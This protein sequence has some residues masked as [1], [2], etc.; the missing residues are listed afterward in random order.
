MN[1]GLSFEDARFQSLLS[2]IRSN[3]AR[4][5]ILEMEG[6]PDGD[7]PPEGEPSEPSPET[8]DLYDH[9]VTSL[10]ESK[11]KKG[12]LH[13][14]LSD[15]FGSNEPDEKPSL[16]Q[17][18]IGH[19]SDKDRPK[20][21]MFHHVGSHAG[22]GAAGG[23]ALGTTTGALIGGAAGSLLGLPGAI[24]G[25]KAG[26]VL[27][28]LGGA[29][30]G[31]IGGIF[32]AHGAAEKERKRRKEAEKEAASGYGKSFTA[33]AGGA[34]LTGAAIAGLG[35]LA[36]KAHDTYRQ[37]QHRRAVLA[38]TVPALQAP[39]PGYGHY[40]SPHPQMAYDQSAMMHP[41]PIHGGHNNRYRGLLPEHTHARSA[42]VD[43][44]VDEIRQRRS[45]TNEERRPDSGL[46]GAGAQALR[47]R[48]RMD[49]FKQVVQVDRQGD[50][51][52]GRPAIIF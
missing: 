19:S 40:P 41:P 33:G 27:G 50:F 29:A 12:F 10:L 25:A 11:D 22:A 16:L 38:Q 34:L 47:S 28:G 30:V 42:L 17:R 21:H 8:Q 37:E 5:A 14:Q 36:S 45:S 46:K 2:Q 18:V 43:S 49:Q 4:S 52:Q 7:T 24:L 23:A 6:T 31:G 13:R 9:L 26:G 39:P 35:A 48:R 44:I 51:I 1:Q 20:E 3:G 15:I 32:S